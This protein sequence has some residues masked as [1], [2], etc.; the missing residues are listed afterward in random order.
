[1]VNDLFHS[2]LEKDFTPEKRDFS[3]SAEA[4]IFVCH[5]AIYPTQSVFSYILKKHNYKY[6]VRSVSE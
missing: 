4:P 3:A 1:M 6:S 5:S 2:N